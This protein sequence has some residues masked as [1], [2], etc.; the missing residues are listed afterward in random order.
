MEIK[1]ITG[2]CPHCHKGVKYSCVEFDSTGETNAS[3]DEVF[4]NSTGTWAVG[5]CPICKMCVLFQFIIQYGCPVKKTYP[6]PFPL[7]VDERIPEKIKKDLEEAKLCFSVGAINSSVGMCRKA[8]QRTCKEKGA[9]KKEL[10]EQIDEIAKKG[11]ISS[12]LKDLAHSVRLIG[13]DGVHPNEDHITREDAEEIL[14]LTEQF[15]EIIFVTPIKIKEIKEK[16]DI[17]KEL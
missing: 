12:D 9:I 17:S 3:F 6:F 1:E 5:E 15:L 4:E 14:N 10:Y 2:F 7:P 16:R 11:I 13:N 8:L